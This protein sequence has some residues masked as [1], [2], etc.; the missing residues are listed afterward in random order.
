MGD[1]P[2]AAL[3]GP[4][5][6]APRGRARQ[7]PRRPAGGRVRP[8]TPPLPAR[9]SVRRRAAWRLLL[10]RTALRRAA[11]GVLPLLALGATGGCQYLP[12]GP[13]YHRPSV[14]V[15]IG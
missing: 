2:P 15:Q 6:W 4:A 14:E 3:L 1:L 8:A 11:W 7:G 10:R 5:R 13:V 12:V 9:C